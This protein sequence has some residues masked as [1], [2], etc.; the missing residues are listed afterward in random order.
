MPFGKHKNTLLKDIPRDYLQWLKGTDL[1]E[2]LKTLVDKVLKA[3][4]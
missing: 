4:K 1:N 3:E 2:P